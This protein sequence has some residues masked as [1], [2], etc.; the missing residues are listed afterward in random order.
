M[1]IYIYSINISRCCGTYERKDVAACQ[2][3]EEYR[4]DYTVYHYFNKKPNN[5]NISGCPNM[6]KLIHSS[7]QDSSLLLLINSHV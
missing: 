7:S 3:R 2:N 5:I 1:A 4:K 6:P